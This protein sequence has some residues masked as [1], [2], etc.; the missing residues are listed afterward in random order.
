MF[1]PTDLLDDL[2]F[3]AGQKKQVVSAAAQRNA[4]MN[5]DQKSVNPIPPV[6]K[7]K[8]PVGQPRDKDGKFKGGP[9]NQ[10]WRDAFARG[11]FDAD[12]A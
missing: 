4:A 2:R 5:A 8:V 1:D 7:A 3:M 11:E 12:T 10:A 6:V 9:R